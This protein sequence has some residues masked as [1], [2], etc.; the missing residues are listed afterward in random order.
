MTDFHIRVCPGGHILHLF[1]GKY[2]RLSKGAAGSRALPYALDV[3]AGNILDCHLSFVPTLIL[4]Q[5][6]MSPFLGAK[7][8]SGCRHF[9]AWEWG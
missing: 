1:G 6:N 9:S 3:P 8:L 4:Q 2:F 5:E 7:R